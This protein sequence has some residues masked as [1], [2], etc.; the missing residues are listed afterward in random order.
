MWRWRW[1]P[2]V[3]KNANF[4][5][6]GCTGGCRCG[7]LPCH[8]LWQSWHHFMTTYA[9]TSY[10]KVGIMKTP[11]FLLMFAD[12]FKSFGTLIWSQNK[13]IWKLSEVIFIVNLPFSKSRQTGGKIYYIR[14]PPIIFSNS[15]HN[16]T[17]SGTH[18]LLVIFW[19]YHAWT[20]ENYI[21]S[22]FKQ[23]S[24]VDGN[25]SF[26]QLLLQAETKISSK[27]HFCFSII[28]KHVRARLNIL[29]V[30]LPRQFSVLW[31]HSR[32]YWSTCD[33]H[34]PLISTIIDK[35]DMSMLCHPWPLCTKRTDVLPQDLVE[36]RNRKVRV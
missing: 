14:R 8:L 6:I 9:V 30:F 29:C 2:G 31:C 34:C 3:A 19:Q 5:V 10:D 24:V 16:C 33:Y 36:F 28:H 20:K 27:W 22:L 25:L 13:L 17:I 7:N 15:Y 35:L 1:K 21:L 23:L 32:K 11:R 12:A 18:Q 4:V 26:W